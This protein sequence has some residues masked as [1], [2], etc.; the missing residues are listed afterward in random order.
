MKESYNKGFTIVELVVSVAILALLIV[1][2]SGIMFSNNIIFKKTKADVNVQEV[3]LDSYNKFSNDMMQ[4]RNIYIEGYSSDDEIT[5]KASKPGYTDTAVD[6]STSVGCYMRGSDVEL[7]ASKP[8][9][10]TYLE[11][12]TDEAGYTEDELKKHRDDLNKLDTAKLKSFNT[13]YEK[14]RY[15]DDEDKELYASYQAYVDSNKSAGAITSFD[16]LKTTDYAHSPAH[17]YKNVYVT[18]MIIQY[19]VPMDN[20]YKTTTSTD[21]YDTCFVTYVFDK[22]EMKITTKYE[23]MTKLNATESV[24][25]NCLNYAVSKN[26]KEVPG[27]LA[28]IDGENDS[29]ELSMYFAK[30]SMSYTSSGISSMRNSYV[31]HDA[32]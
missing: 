8:A 6:V 12:I 27:V 14:I 13:Y 11:F 3:A 15:M 22:N 4:A 19:Y 5:F 7:R 30:N 29:I 9:T 1:A 24:Y 17:T 31:L 26:G 21:A 16:T 18:K 25:T 2:I 10:K 20:K 28:R 32:K 23:N